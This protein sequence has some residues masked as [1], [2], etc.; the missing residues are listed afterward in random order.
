MSVPTEPAGDLGPGP[1]PL[2][3]EPWE[4]GP[5]EAGLWRRALHRFMAHRLAVT[6]IVV[7]AVIVLAV[8]VGPFLSSYDPAEPKLDDIF[9]GPSLAHPFGT[10]SVGRDE[11]TRVLYGGRIS[12]L[13]GGLAVAV[14]ITLGLVV[15]AIAGFLGG[16]VDVALMRFVDLMLSFPRLYLLI[17][18]S[19]FLRDRLPSVVII[20]VVLG[21]LSWM[22]TARLV[23]ASFL[24]LRQREFVEAARAAGA[25]NRHL[26]LRHLLPNAMSPIIVAASLGM[27]TA[28]IS[29][30]TLSFLGLGI[31]P[32]TAS[33]GNMLK[34]AE[35]DMMDAPWVAV[36]PGLAIFLVVVAINFIGDGLRDALDPR[37][38]GGRRG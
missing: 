20:I 32:P 8:V 21:T 35:T 11:L 33:W 26:V 12:L 38:V 34:D 13:V 4:A 15:G 5:E 30:S 7:L 18:A 17:L 6:S 29:E 36:F 2:A 25:R 10:D 1:S 16:A 28:I 23:R 31:Q 14:A 37:H 19:V 9:V 27:A 24:S 3:G 22:G